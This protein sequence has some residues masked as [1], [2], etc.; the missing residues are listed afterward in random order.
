MPIHTDTTLFQMALV[1]YEAERQK[2]Q[3][4]IAELRAPLNAIWHTGGKCRLVQD[5][6]RQRRKKKVRPAAGRAVSSIRRAPARAWAP[7]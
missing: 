5:Q 4:K 3:G 2:I 6:M 7:L 1:G